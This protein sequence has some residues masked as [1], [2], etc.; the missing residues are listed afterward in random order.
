MNTSRRLALSL[1][2]TLC[3]PLVA[4]ANAT[5]LGEVLSR[6][7]ASYQGQGMSNSHN[8]TYET[9]A[10]GETHRYEATVRANSS[11]VIHADCG[12]SCTDVDLF[13]YDQYGN[14]VAQ[15]TGAAR[16]A[17]VHIN[18]NGTT[19]LKFGV[20]MAGCSGRSCPVGTFMMLKP[21]AQTAGQTQR[22]SNSGSSEVG[23][24]E[25]AVVVGGLAILC[26]LTDCA[27]GSSDSGSSSTDI[28]L[29]RRRREHE[30]LCRN[31]RNSGEDAL[32][33][34]EGC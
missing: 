19:E 6:A 1:A 5:T 20:H 3:A 28:G 31:L 14:V 7:Q 17:S 12:G 21:S 16:A 11:Y 33:S 23:W 15:D 4:Q 8:L 25:V 32:A 30:A 2:L 22:R 18:T 24:G 26:A 9:L 10:R 29:E 27:G 34:R 13:V